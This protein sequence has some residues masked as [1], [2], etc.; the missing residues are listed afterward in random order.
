MC[1]L[2]H[3]MMIPCKRLTE[4][5]LTLVKGIEAQSK[6]QSNFDPKHKL[7]FPITHVSHVN[8]GFSSD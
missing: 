1:E 3:A 5:K 8:L 6:K 7:K 4:S 2:H